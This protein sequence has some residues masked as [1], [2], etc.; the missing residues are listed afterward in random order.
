MLARFNFGL[1]A[2]ADVMLLL[3]TLALYL[4]LNRVAKNAMLVA[5]ALLAL[6]AVV[7]LAITELNSLTLVTLTEQYGAAVGDAQRSAYLA[8]ADYALATLPIATFFSFFESSV[9]LLIASVIM[10]KG[11]FSRITAY[12]GLVASIEGII[13]SFYPVIPAL[14]LLL[15]PCLVAFGIWSILA[16]A[17]LY[18]LGGQPAE[19]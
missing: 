11:I 4:S 3:G 15:T 8:A 1:F 12:A 13:A 6:F 2:L 10:L 19:G 7:D 5:T 9:G 14:A 16:G 17:R 18:Q